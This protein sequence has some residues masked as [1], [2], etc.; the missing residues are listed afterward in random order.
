MSDAI[1]V[2]SGAMVSVCVVPTAA[3]D[4]LIVAPDSAV[5]T[6]FSALVTFVPLTENWALCAAV[7]W[8]HPA[9]PSEMIDDA[10]TAVPVAGAAVEAG[11]AV[12]APVSSA[13]ELDVVTVTGLAELLLDEPTTRCC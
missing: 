7:V 12:V 11:S 4:R 5:E 3:A 13:S 1:V 2:V 8:V 6:V 10:P 9:E